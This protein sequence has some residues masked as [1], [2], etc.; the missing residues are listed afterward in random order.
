MV[1][2]AGPSERSAQQR[3]PSG[4]VIS[5]QKHHFSRVC[6]VQQRQECYRLEKVLRGEAQEK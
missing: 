1:L 2:F 6:Q 4:A 3:L 5:L